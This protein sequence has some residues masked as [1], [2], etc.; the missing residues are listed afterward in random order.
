MVP[1]FSST[2]NHNNIIV[3]FLIYPVLLEL[4][5]LV[6]LLYYSIYYIISYL[7]WNLIAGACKKLRNKIDK[8]K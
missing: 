6:I 2:R 5:I 4:E 1:F 3:I 8:V 7:Y